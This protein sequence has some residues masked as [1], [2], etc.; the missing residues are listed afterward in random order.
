MDAVASNAAPPVVVAPQAPPAPQASPAAPQASPVATSTPASTGVVPPPN[1]AS[2][3]GVGLKKGLEAMNNRR[4]AQDG[5]LPRHAKA[6]SGVVGELD[7][8]VISAPEISLTLADG[9]VVTARV[10]R[11]STDSKRGAQT[12]IGTFDSSPGSSLVLTKSAGTVSGF[13][14]ING[15]T[16]EIL[17]STAGKHVLFAVDSSQLPK[18]DGVIKFDSS[19]GNALTTTSSYDVGTSTTTAAG[20]TVVQDLLVVYTAAAANAWSKAGGNDPV[21]SS[22]VESGLCQ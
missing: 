1:A 19:G 11:L 7:A 20:S 22:V 18:Y 12:W 17:P 14:N 16:L 3:S 21:R 9:S 2:Q 8:G 10:Q 13:A 15:Q 5:E 4:P 6:Q